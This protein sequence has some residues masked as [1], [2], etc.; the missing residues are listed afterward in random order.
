MAT[1]RTATTHWEGTL[2]EGAGKVTLESSG[3]RHVRRLLGLARRGGQR[4]DQPRGA[5]RR[6]AL[7]L[8]LDGAVQRPGQGR[9]PAAPRSTPRPTSTSSPAPA[10]P[11]SS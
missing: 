8:L 11:A 10:S 6:G 1:T 5:D 4:Q 3:H 7:R 9:H 2:I